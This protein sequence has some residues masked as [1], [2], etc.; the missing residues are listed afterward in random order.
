MEPPEH[1]EAGGLW[2][3]Q[4]DV[5]TRDWRSASDIYYS[6]G[7]AC[8]S[9]ANQ[10][11]KETLDSFPPGFLPCVFS[12]CVGEAGDH[13]CKRLMLAFVLSLETGAEYPWIAG[14]LMVRVGLPNSAGSSLFGLFGSRPNRTNALFENCRTEQ[15]M[16]LKSSVRDTHEPNNGLFGSSLLLQSNRRRSEKTISALPAR[17]AIWETHFPRISDSAKD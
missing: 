15:G 12:N 5:E 9:I 10:C 7:K 16:V 2:P 6:I 8:S 3:A 14:S 1:V 17:S 11:P 13:M 4:D